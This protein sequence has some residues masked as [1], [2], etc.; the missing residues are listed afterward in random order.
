[1]YKIG[2]TSFPSL[3]SFFFLETRQGTPHLRFQHML[4]LTA[5]LFVLRRPLL[6]E[7]KPCLGH[8]I[9]HA[10]LLHHFQL[11]GSLGQNHPGK[12]QRVD[13]DRTESLL[14]ARHNHH[15]LLGQ[16]P[17]VGKGR[18]GGRAQNALLV[19]EF[20]LL[21]VLSNRHHHGVNERDVGLDQNVL[22]VLVA[23]GGIWEQDDVVDAV[24]GNRK[25]IT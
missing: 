7:N 1:M 16:D 17:V 3:L 12:A 2:L 13:T 19:R 23:S 6:M 24:E 25:K 18:H 22:L 15:K 20:L 11:P 14:L 8:H 4:Y 5:L 9:H 21:G 10:S